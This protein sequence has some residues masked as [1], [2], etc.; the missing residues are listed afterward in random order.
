MCCYMQYVHI[1]TYFDRRV[2]LEHWPCC[3][4]S[5]DAENCG[6]ENWKIM[7]IFYTP[8]VDLAVG[9]PGIF[10]M[11]YFT[12]YV[13]GLFYYWLTIQYIIIVC[14]LQLDKMRFILLIRWQNH[15]VCDSNKLLLTKKLAELAPHY[16]L[17]L[18]FIYHEW[19][20]WRSCG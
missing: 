3:L 4:V 10:D 13:L 11:L 16:L 2:Y 20:Y 1:G 9:H 6:S 5:M 18:F 15:L 19:F 12:Y 8:E 14:N 7:L 17:C